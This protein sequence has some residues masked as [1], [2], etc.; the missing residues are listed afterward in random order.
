MIESKEF[1]RFYLT[2]VQEAIEIEKGE[3]GFYIVSCRE[4][5][6]CH[7]QGETIQEA[8]ENIRDAIKDYKEVMDSKI[9]SITETER[10]KGSL[11][12]GKLV[13]WEDVKE[14]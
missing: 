11:H 2:D 12:T 10:F 1:I 6:G 14:G 7:S 5:K 13:A 8:I 9:I 4:L 3:D